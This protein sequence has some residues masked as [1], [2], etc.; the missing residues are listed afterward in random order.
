MSHLGLRPRV[1]VARLPPDGG[2]ADAPC[3][4]AAPALHLPPLLV[5]LHQLVAARPLAP[6]VVLPRRG[7]TPI[8]TQHG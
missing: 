5:R 3:A 7:P 2:L 4:A 6:P 1:E 8:T